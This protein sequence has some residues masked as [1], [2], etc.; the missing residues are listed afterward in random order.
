MNLIF[1]E[2]GQVKACGREA[3][4]ELI[5]RLEIITGKRCGSL[6]TGM[7]DLP[8]AYVLARQIYS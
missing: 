1:D 7:L 8:D 2:D 5:R 3:C 6:Q 4:M